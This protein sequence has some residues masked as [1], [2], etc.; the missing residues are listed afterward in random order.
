MPIRAVVLD[1]GGVLE[2]TPDTGWID[3][4]NRILNRNLIEI[5]EQLEE[6]GIDGALGTCSEAEWVD[7][8][9]DVTGM[10]QGKVDAFMDDLWKDY[11]GE[12]NVE[13]V[14]FIHTLRPQYQTAILSNSFVGARE[15]EQALY[16]FEDLVDFLVYSHEVGLLKPDPRIYALTCERLGLPPSEVV[17]LDDAEPNII[18]AREFGMQAILFQETRQAINDLRAC[19]SA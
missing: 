5:L 8:L 16:H 15:K 10:D 13:L 18:G 12:L 11:L 17:F 19:L 3:K 7:G 2:I 9:R 1:I 4:W 14:D 6:M